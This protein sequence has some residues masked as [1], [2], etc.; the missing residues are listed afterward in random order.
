MTSLQTVV[1]SPRHEDEWRELYAAYARFYQTSLSAD[2]AGRVWEWI[3]QGQLRGLGVENEQ[4]ALQGIAHWA[5]I[6]RPL[7][8]QP[9]AYLHDLFVTPDARGQG[10]AR[11]LI[12]AA[13]RQAK[14]EGCSTMRW[15]TAADNETAMR[16][17]DRIAQKTQWV[18]YERDN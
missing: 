16:L 9:M 17:Y 7:R 15:A 2:A 4:G 5:V 11:A 18:I 12:H 10:A 13:S 14:E 6:L 3:G 1:L 8:A